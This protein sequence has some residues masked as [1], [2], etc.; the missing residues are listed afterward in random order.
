MSLCDGEFVSGANCIEMDRIES[1]VLKG[2]NINLKLRVVDLIVLCL[3]QP[4]PQSL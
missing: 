4:F 2:E 3:F 1:A